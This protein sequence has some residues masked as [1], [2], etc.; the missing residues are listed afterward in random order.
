MEP[1]FAYGYALQGRL[2][3]NV[4][5]GDYALDWDFIAINLIYKLI[6]QKLHRTCLNASQYFY[7]KWE[8]YLISLYFSRK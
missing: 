1:P 6:I 7:L 8:I 4:T 5:L 3:E 2:I